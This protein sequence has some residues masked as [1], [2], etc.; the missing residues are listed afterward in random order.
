MTAFTM[1]EIELGDMVIFHQDAQNPGAVQPVIGWVCE[2]PGR[3]TV[4]ILT[5]TPETGF[6]DKR[7]VRHASDPFWKE[8]EN[9][10]TWS[11]HG[12][13]DYHPTTKLLKEVRGLLSQ[14]KI[15]AAK[16]EAV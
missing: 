9:A 6:V 5:F 1:P 11:R 7:S 15:A 10:G 14:A 2:H 12:S 13:W 3:V 4:S 16:K 8:D